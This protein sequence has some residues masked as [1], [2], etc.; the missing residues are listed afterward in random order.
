MHPTVPETGQRLAFLPSPKLAGVVRYLHV[1][2]GSG[3]TVMVPANP[4]AMLT[5]FLS[6][7]TYT[8]ADA[9]PIDRP[10]LCGPL[11]APAT[12]SWLPGTTFVTAQLA[13]EYLPLLFGVDAAALARQPL[14]LSELGLDTGALERQ[15]QGNADAAVWIAAVEAWLL[16][17]LRRCEGRHALFS[18]PASALA[19]P[20]ATLAGQCGIS[21]RQLERRF[22]ASYGQTIRERRRMQRYL[23]ALSSLLRAPV[24]HGQ[25]TRVAQDAG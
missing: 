9:P 3:G 15:L 6:G 18:L 25:L 24:R 20:T 22:A 21:V 4:Y 12:A 11:L 10:L 13:P 8:A 16:A 14:L 2:R 7:G 5:F 1:E 17:L 19:L 23:L